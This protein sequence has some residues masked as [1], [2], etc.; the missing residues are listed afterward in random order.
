MQAQQEHRPRYPNPLML[1]KVR[2]ITCELGKESLDLYMHRC[3]CEACA[4]LFAQAL[5][6][7]VLGLN[8][9]WIDIDQIR[10]WLER[11]RDNCLDCNSASSLTQR[12]L[13]LIDVEQRCL[14]S[15]Q[16][17]DRQYL[18]LSYVWG[19]VDS[20]ETVKKNIE[21]LRV[22]GSLACI[23]VRIPRI[24]WDAMGVTVALGERYL[25]VDRLCICQDDERTKSHEIQAM[26]SIYANSLM[27]IISSIGE[28]ADSGLAGIPG[29][30]RPREIRRDSH[31]S[32]TECNE[33]TSRWL[34]HQC[35]WVS[36]LMFSPHVK[37]SSLLTCQSSSICMFSFAWLWS[38]V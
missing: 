18:A 13:W 9:A 8:Q 4:A 25:W 17:N 31:W 5:Q 10:R 23:N 26:G 37:Y 7:D 24:I 3:G 16:P 2:D 35:A 14:V 33:T 15:G 22:P 21:S 32:E 38:S 36:Q 1:D 11:C 6:K 30:T 27:T 19:S 12:P 28:N 34:R 20:T 29:V